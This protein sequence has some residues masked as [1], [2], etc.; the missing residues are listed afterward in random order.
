MPAYADERYKA[1]DFP[2]AE[3]CAQ[4]VLSLPLH[5]HMRS[6]QVAEVAGQILEL[7]G[8]KHQ[9]IVLSADS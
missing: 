6:E 2:V 3:A 9:E 7:A 8:K 4:T 5:A 1:G